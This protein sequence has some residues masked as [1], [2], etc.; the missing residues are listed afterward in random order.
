MKHTD[1]I[2]RTLLLP[3]TVA[4]TLTLNASVDYRI[5]DTRGSMLPFSVQYYDR[6]AAGT[7][8][9][10]AYAGPLTLVQNPANNNA[11]LPQTLSTYCLDV[12]GGLVAGWT[13]QFNVLDFAGLDGLK[14]KWGYSASDAGQAIQ[15]AA[16]LYN[17]FSLG[18]GLPSGQQIAGTTAER[19]GLQLAIWESLY[20][21]GYGGGL[22]VT[23]G[24]ASGAGRHFSLTGSYSGATASAITAANN[25]LAQLGNISGNPT[26]KLLQPFAPPNY[27][28]MPYQEVLVPE[29]A[30]L[31]AG[32]L[33]ALPFGL[34]SVRFMRRRQ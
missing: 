3:A 18:I 28:G 15:N 32:A 11:L 17:A 19:A 9:E 25:Y 21:T 34:T 30:T 10:A 26:G 16:K 33:M 5:V 8:S 29:P 24:G 7:S 23:T 31:V 2:W 22:D 20:D 1:M 4:A 6:V 27:A 12:G 13:Y 14:P